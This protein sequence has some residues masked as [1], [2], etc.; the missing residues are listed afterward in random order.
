VLAQRTL[1]CLRAIGVV[2][3]AGKRG[4]APLHAVSG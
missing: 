4:R 3:A 1:Y 2:E